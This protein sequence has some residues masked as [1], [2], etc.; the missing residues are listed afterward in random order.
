M[1][2]KSLSKYRNKEEC[3]YAEECPFAAVVP[4][5][6][7]IV[8]IPAVLRVRPFMRKDAFQTTWT[9]L[10]VTAIERVI[11]LDVLLIDWVFC[12]AL[13]YEKACNDTG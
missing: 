3:Q 11:S 10:S 5:I 1:S 12:G 13:S 8:H 9:N 7:S 4:V 6:P 2:A